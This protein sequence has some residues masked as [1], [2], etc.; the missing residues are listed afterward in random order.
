MNKLLSLT[1]KYPRVYFKD[2]YTENEEMDVITKAEQFAQRF[3]NHQKNMGDPYYVHLD[4]V[5][6][7]VKQ[8][9]AKNNRGPLYYNAVEDTNTTPVKEVVLRLL[10]SC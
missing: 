6:N 3:K 1:L 7:I 10:N 2:I 9:G 8:A 4:E 5:R